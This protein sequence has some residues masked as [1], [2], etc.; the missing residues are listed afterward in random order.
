[1]VEK[2]YVLGW[3]LAGIGEHPATRDTWVF[4]GGTCLKKCFFETY[5]FSEDLDFTLTDP[6]HLDEGFSCANCLRKW[7]SG[8]TTKR[9]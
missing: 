1:V 3:L 9:V 2:D 8:C 6:A 5:R 4:K 7:A